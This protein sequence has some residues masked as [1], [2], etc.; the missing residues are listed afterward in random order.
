MIAENGENISLVNVRSFDIKGSGHFMRNNFLVL[1]HL[2]YDG[3]Q[4]PLFQEIADAVA[5][6]ALWHYFGYIT[7]RKYMQSSHKEQGNLSPFDL[8]YEERLL[9]Y[10]AVYGVSSI[11]IPFGGMWRPSCTIFQYLQ[12]CSKKLAATQSGKPSSE[13][14]IKKIEVIDLSL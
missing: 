9:N 2:D 8:D 11:K 6:N 12:K 10:P 4:S 14:L 7:T 5:K 13:I 3:E 1:V